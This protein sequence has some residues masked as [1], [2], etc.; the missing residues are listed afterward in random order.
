MRTRW[1]IAAVLVAIGLVWIA[2]ATN[3]LPGSGGMYG[4]GRW[5]VAGAVVA[6]I[7]VFVGWAAFRAGRR[8]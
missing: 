5:G 4:D 1:I 6:V 8:A 7:G 2:Q 3:V